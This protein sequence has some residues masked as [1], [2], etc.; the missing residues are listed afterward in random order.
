M[1]Q[2]SAVIAAL[3]MTLL[4]GAAIAV[5]GGNAYLNS[6]TLPIENAPGQASTTTPAP[7]TVSQQSESASQEQVKQ[8]QNLIAQYQAREKQYQDQ[9]NEATQRLQ[10]ANSEIQQYQDLLSALQDRGVIRVGR[11][12]QIFIPREQGVSGDDDESR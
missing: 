12:G 3:V 11:G 2:I 9:L 6:N 10:Q 7:A 4:T 8:L 1:K 5:I